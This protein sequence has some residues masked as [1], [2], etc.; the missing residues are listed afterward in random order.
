[1]NQRILVTGSSGLIGTAIRS[2][3]ASKGIETVCLDLKAQGASCG[4]ICNK[5][6]VRRLMAGVDGVIHLAAVSRVVWGQ[7]NPELCWETNV[8]GVQNVL[9]AAREAS[10]RPWVISASSREVYGEAEHLPVSEDMPLRPVNIYGRSKAEG[11]RLV[12]E[13]AKAGMRASPL[14]LSN[15]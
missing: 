5:E 3:L 14:R 9:D 7:K 1:M 6:D 15:V 4:D 13:A 11:E 10:S 12:A 2:L 8:T